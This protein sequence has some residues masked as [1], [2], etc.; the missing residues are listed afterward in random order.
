M[1]VILTAHY[2]TY[3]M[4]VVVGTRHVY[5]RFTMSSLTVCMLCCVSIRMTSSALTYGGIGAMEAIY[6]SFLSAILSVLHSKLI[7]IQN[8]S[9]EL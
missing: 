9:S 6:S 3:T 8:P 5:G 2:M 4:Y 7:T 1:T